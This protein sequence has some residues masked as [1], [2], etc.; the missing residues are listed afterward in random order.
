MKIRNFHDRRLL[1]CLAFM[2]AV[3]ILLSTGS[4][5]AMGRESKSPS[6]DEAFEQE[7]LYLL[8]ELRYDNNLDPLSAFPDLDDASQV[9]ADELIELFSHTRPNGESCFSILNE[10]SINYFAAGENIAAGHQTPEAVMTG[11]YNSPGHRDNMLSADFSHVG[12]GHTYASGTQYGHH[13]VQLFVGGCNFSGISIA[14]PDETLTFPVGTSLDEIADGLFYTVIANCSMHGASSLPLSVHM[15]SGY[16]DSLSGT[17]TITVSCY[18]YTTTLTIELV[19]PTPEPPTPEP[20]TTEPPTTEPP[21]TEPPTEA[22]VANLIYGTS[23]EDKAE[24]NEWGRIDDD[25]DGHNWIWSAE[26]DSDYLAYEGE[27][28][29]TSASYINDGICGKSAINP[30]NRLVSPVIDI[31]ANAVEAY[32]SFYYVGQDYEWNAENF[33]VYVSIDGGETWSDEL[34]YYT[35][36]AEYQNAVIDLM[37]YAGESVNIAIRHYDITDMFMLNIDLFEVYATT[38]DAPVTEPPT[39]DPPT[40]EPPTTE[41]PTTEPPTS[42][43]PTTEP[44]TTEPPTTEP[45]TTEPPTTEPPTTEPPTTE[46]PTGYDTG[47]VNMDGNVNTGDA[48]LVLR[49]AVSLETLTDEQLI[50]SDFNA[51]YRVDTGDAAAILRFAVGL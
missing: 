51:D 39:T 20:P 9:R 26:E 44:P 4:V 41:P 11:W 23:F 15:C 8:N 7:T 45:P 35:S 1:G 28:V 27:H 30:D 34:G 29:M 25:G 14:Q 42:E 21:T 43:P 19:A 5:Y 12:I 3:F 18:G 36:S 10:Y 50:L 22:P 31:P 24:V 48:A 46:P 38:E 2:L 17:Q 6:R 49:Y 33:G 13:W 47:D 40:S 16:D 37:D 32:V